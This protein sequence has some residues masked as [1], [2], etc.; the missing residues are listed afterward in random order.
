LKKRKSE[1]DFF[2]ILDT[3]KSAGAKLSILTKERGVIIGI[4]H[5]VDEYDADPERLGY[6]VMLEPHLGDTV[7][8]DEI[9]DI[10]VVPKTVD[11]KEA[12]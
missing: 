11:L 3:A 1:K 4:P 9:V 5:N 7:F 10:K 2:G 12:I 8:L 6:F